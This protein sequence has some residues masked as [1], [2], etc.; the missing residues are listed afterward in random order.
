MRRGRDAQGLRTGRRRG[1]SGRGDDV[2]NRG[3]WRWG[4]RGRGG[5]VVV[6]PGSEVGGQGATGSSGGRR[7]LKEGHVLKAQ[8]LVQEG[9]GQRVL[10][11]REE[12]HLRERGG[13][14]VL[15]VVVVVVAQRTA[16]TA[17]DGRFGGKTWSERH[18]R[19][20]SS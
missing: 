6:W 11:E 17:R 19:N 10:L 14:A 7:G 3:W 1:G 8:V 9:G 12:A 4:R 15:V 5:T 18:A 13:G 16:G 20:K 2:M